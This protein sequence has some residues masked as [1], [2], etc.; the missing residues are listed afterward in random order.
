MGTSESTLASVSSSL[1]YLVQYSLKP[2]GEPVLSSVPDPFFK[3]WSDVFLRAVIPPAAP[4]SSPENAVSLGQSQDDLIT[5]VA[6]HSLRPRSRRF[7]LMT[8]CLV[9]DNALQQPQFFQYLMGRVNSMPLSLRL[10]SV[11][12]IIHRD[13]CIKLQPCL[14]P[15][16]AWHPH[17][18]SLV[19][20]FDLYQRQ[21]TKS[22]SF[23]LGAMFLIAA[24]HCHPLSSTLMRSLS[25]TVDLIGSQLMLS[26]SHD[27][28]F[29]QALEL[30]LAQ[31]P[32][33]V[34]TSFHGSTK[35]EQAQRGHSL[36]GI[37]M[38]YAAMAA[39]RELGLDQAASTLF[40]LIGKKS[41]DTLSTPLSESDQ[42]QIPELL[43]RV[44]LWSS[45][46]LWECYFVFLKT[47]ITIQRDLDVLAN[48]VKCMISVDAR[49]S[50]I[51]ATPIEQEGISVSSL[52]SHEKDT[53]NKL[54]SAGRTNLAYRLQTMA[55]VQ[56][57]LGSVED[58]VKEAKRET[59]TTPDGCFKV[60]GERQD[61]I[62][63]LI[64]GAIEEQGRVEEHRRLDMAPSAF[65][66]AA[67]L[68][69]E[70]FQLESSHLIS[71]LCTYGTG[72]LSAGHF[73]AGMSP[74]HFI[75]ILN[76]DMGLWNRI[77]TLGARRLDLCENI[78]SSFV[79]FNRRL[80][81]TTTPE[82]LEQKKLKGVMELTGAPVF[83]TCAILVDSCKLFLEGVAFV[84]VK[85]SVI[86]NNYDA[87]LLSMVQA[88]QRLEEMDG[89]RYEQQEDENDTDAEA[90]DDADADGGNEHDGST[91]NQPYTLPKSFYHATAQS[92][93]EM[94]EILQKWKLASSIYR[95]PVTADKKSDKETKTTTS[96]TGS[97][98]ESISSL[99]STNVDN[100]NEPAAT[101]V[102][103]MVTPD[104]QSDP[105][106][107]NAAG[108]AEVPMNSMLYSQAPPLQSQHYTSNHGQVMYPPLVHGQFPMSSLDLWHP[109]LYN[110]TRYNGHLE[111]LL[112]STFP[113]PITSSSTSRTSTGT[114]SADGGTSAVHPPL[115]DGFFESFFPN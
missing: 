106:N 14:T 72:S 21:P 95:R 65:H 47:S 26:S 77:C 20:M 89:N 18:R 112:A 38:F 28:C 10:P 69:E 100:N 3:V 8:L 54:R 5:R 104:P 115:M 42:S 107:S 92:I 63:E 51:D 12:D 80:T 67:N 64:L 109:N 83:L 48:N 49:G 15:Y 79:F 16:L 24:R 96:D 62:V 13:E 29:V 57:T 87:R 33:L 6:S 68:A 27:V 76:K 70:W 9:M 81:I 19:H 86:Q 73:D 36:S 110:N 1:S 30:L 32:T 39:S 99:P 75:Q 78:V 11:L 82:I 71:V 60:S 113:G 2:V 35:E 74:Y 105:L 97:S 114:T 43:M 84:L 55:I 88:A 44:S 85:Y 98:A 53:E 59:Q 22:A 91:K 25:T 4:S 31:D 45:L 37:T 90:A 61:Q 52:A 41:C 103:M 23:L 108:T 102:S 40:K 94:V 56:R 93:R 46:R 50:R 66:N 111:Q 7:L 58:I 101:S 17:L 34:G